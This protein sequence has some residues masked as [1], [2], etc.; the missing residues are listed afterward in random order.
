MQVSTMLT[1]LL[2]TRDA[3]KQDSETY[4][5]LIGELVADAQKRSTAKRVAGGKRS[6]LS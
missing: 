4:N 3:L 2:Q 5:K 1:H 6:T